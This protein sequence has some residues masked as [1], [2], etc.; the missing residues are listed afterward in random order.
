MT[1]SYQFTTPKNYGAVGDGIADDTQSFSLASVTGNTI[2]VPKGTYRI[3]GDVSFFT[4]LD[5]DYGA[6]L[7]IEG[8]VVITG[9][10]LAGNYKVFNVKPSGKIIG[11]TQAKVEWFG[12]AANGITDSYSAIQTMLRCGVKTVEYGAGTYYHSSTVQLYGNSQVTVRGAG[13][14]NTSLTIGA[15]SKVDIIISTCIIG[16]NNVDV[17]A[18]GCYLWRCRAAYVIAY[19]Y[20]AAKC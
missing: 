13:F 10:V 1:Y 15:A 4:S 16:P 18:R 7:L 17:A 11:L 20:S 19:V 6:V 12:A 8:T 2:K 14:R 9:E 3:C 5:F